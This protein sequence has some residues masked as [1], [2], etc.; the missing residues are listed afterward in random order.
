MTIEGE[1]FCIKILN[2]IM[3]G[4]NMERD[5]DEFNEE[6]LDNVLGGISHE[7]AVEKA[8]EYSYKQTMIE[9]LKRE[10]EILEQSSMEFDKNG[11]GRK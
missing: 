6:E 11:R 9:E 2:F 8:L 1:K 10:K 7:L 3:G 5:Y 4:F